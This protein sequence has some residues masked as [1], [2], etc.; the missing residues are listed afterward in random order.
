MVLSTGAFRGNHMVFTMVLYLEY[1]HFN[2]N[3]I[4]SADLSIFYL[5]QACLD[6]IAFGEV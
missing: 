2:W 1:F 6:C 3:N 4:L 5:L